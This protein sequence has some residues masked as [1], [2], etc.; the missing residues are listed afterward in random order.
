MNAQS[1]KKVRPDAIHLTLRN[2]AGMARICAEYLDSGNESGSASVKGGMVNPFSLLSLG[3][4]AALTA[5]AAPASP[6]AWTAEPA[7]AAKPPVC[8]TH[9]VADDSD[10]GSTV[11]VAAHSDVSILLKTVDGA[12][13]SAPT[14][15]GR[16]LGPARP[17]PTPF[18][19]VGWQFRTLAAGHSEIATTRK[20]C[21]SHATAAKQCHDVVY[22]LHVTVR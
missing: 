22:H 11:C 17:L 1:H 8:A 21:P 13:W 14:R 20:S 15:T 10:N 6:T 18:G 12:P 5:G 7:V 2:R 19:H 9:V 4:V 16:V 3:L